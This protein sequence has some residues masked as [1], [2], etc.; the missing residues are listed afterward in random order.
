MAKEFEKP[1]EG[2]LQTGIL[3]ESESSDGSPIGPSVS[4]NHADAD[5]G[6]AATS[7]RKFAVPAVRRVSG[8]SAQVKPLVVAPLGKHT[9]TV[10]VAHGL[11]DSGAGWVFLAEQWLMAKKFEEVKFIFPNAPSIP[12][13]IV[14]LARA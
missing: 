9:A 12:I 6:V 10:I 7:I 1:R 4:W 3:S 8:M 11:G 2:S 5:Q 13:T 14:G